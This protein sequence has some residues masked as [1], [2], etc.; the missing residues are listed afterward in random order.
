LK[1]KIEL[2]LDLGEHFTEEWQQKL[3]VLLERSDGFMLMVR[4]REGDYRFLKMMMTSQ[5]V[6]KFIVA[7]FEEDDAVR[8][9]VS[10]KL[11]KRA[12]IT[13]LVKNNWNM[14]SGQLFAR[15]GKDQPTI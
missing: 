6:G 5:E 15:L 14:S 13:V 10:K 4:E 9:Y 8:S 12:K 7:Y 2:E 11:G 3:K 1:T